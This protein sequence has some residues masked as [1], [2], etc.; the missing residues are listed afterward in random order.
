MTITS[1]VLIINKKKG[2]EE[3]KNKKR[4]KIFKYMGLRYK[5]YF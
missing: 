4:S 5:K 2:N 3:R 1:K